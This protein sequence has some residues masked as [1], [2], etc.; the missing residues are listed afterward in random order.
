MIAINFGPLQTDTERLK[1]RGSN[2]CFDIRSILLNDVDCW[3]EQTLSTNHQYLLQQSFTRG[4]VFSPRL[5]LWLLLWIRFQQSNKIKR[6]LNQMLKPCSRA[7]KGKGK[8]KQTN[9]E[10]T[11]AQTGWF[12]S[13]LLLADWSSRAASPT[14]PANHLIAAARSAYSKIISGLQTEF[15]RCEQGEEAW[16]E[17]YSG[18]R[19]ELVGMLGLGLQKWLAKG[20][21]DG[22]TYISSQVGRSKAVPN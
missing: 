19:G 14:T 22:L 21:G 4:L 3:G 6:M 11:N 20:P 10:K 9:K 5:Q 15:S 18:F 13:G 12:Y 16:H 17:R 1:S 8:N 2:I 7:F